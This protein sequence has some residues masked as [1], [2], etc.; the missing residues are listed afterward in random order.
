MKKNIHALLA[1][2]MIGD[3]MVN[4]DLSTPNKGT[5]P[6]GEVLNKKNVKKIIPR[7]CKEYFFNDDGFCYN[8]KKNNEYSFSCI[9]MSEKS[10]TKKFNKWKSKKL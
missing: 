1:M 2:A 7:G 3:I 4:N 6:N 5:N 8:A 10:A 9:A